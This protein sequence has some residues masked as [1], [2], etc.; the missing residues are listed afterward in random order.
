MTKT[1]YTRSCLYCQQNFYTTDKIKKY[2]DLSCS[3]LDRN[4]KILQIKHE[5]Y[6]T[7][8]NIC[9]NCQDIISY[10]KRNNKFC[11][12]S[13]AATHNNKKRGPR[14]IE[15]KKKTLLTLL[16]RNAK[17]KKQNNENKKPKVVTQTYCIVCNN[18]TYKKR[19]TCSNEC[20]SIFFSNLKKG[21][22]GGN[23]DI[24]LPGIDSFGKKFYFDSA[25]EV[26]L[27][28]DLNANNIL[29]HRPERFILS[30]GRGYTPDFY[31]PTYN[32]FVDPK[33]KRPNYYRESIL[34][35]EMFEKEFDTKCL[36]IS[37]K[38]LLTW[39]HILTMMLVK[40]YRS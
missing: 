36:V 13:C 8:P 31:I 24:N 22:F 16:A 20:Y 2:C 6:L 18:S 3:T 19:K 21:K 28:N 10:E 27:A 32:I 25:W 5:K 9:L 7:D 23:T 38:N 11:S 37:N 12:N 30:N 40:N 1:T 39:S 4:Q 29:W 14:T 15:S 35:I 17:S 33:A 34:K 26:D